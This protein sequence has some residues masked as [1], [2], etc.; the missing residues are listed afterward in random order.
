MCIPP[1]L[2]GGGWGREGEGGG[3]RMIRTWILNHTCHFVHILDYE[4]IDG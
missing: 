1:L 3:G 2:G 4:L